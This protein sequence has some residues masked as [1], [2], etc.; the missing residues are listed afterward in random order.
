[1]ANARALLLVREAL[2][3]ASGAEP[4]LRFQIVNQRAR[5]TQRPVRLPPSWTQGS[6]MRRAGEEAEQLEIAV[7]CL[8]ACGWEL[9]PA[10]T[11]DPGPVTA[12][13]PTVA[14]TTAR[15]GAAQASGAGRQLYR[16]LATANIRVGPVRLRRPHHQSLI[17]GPL[18]TDLLKRARAMCVCSAPANYTTVARARR[19]S[20]RRGSGR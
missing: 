2:A 10:A 9:P 12:A 14:A 13:A 6:G 16:V 17:R 7:D 3:G 1:M 11:D 20:R 8:A 4:S 15:V 18:L 19:R 5:G